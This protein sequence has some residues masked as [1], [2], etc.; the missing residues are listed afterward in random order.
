MDVYEILMRDHRLTEQIFSDIEKTTTAEV[1]RREQL[2]DEL[3]NRWH[4][5]RKAGQLAQAL[6][7]PPADALPK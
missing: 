4:L 7:V 2:F 6:A 5:T 1:R 3:R